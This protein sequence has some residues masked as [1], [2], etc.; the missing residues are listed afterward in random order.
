MR[1]TLNQRIPCESF[2]LVTTRSVI[3]RIATLIAGIAVEDLP[4]YLGDYEVAKD[5]INTLKQHSQTVHTA[6]HNGRKVYDQ[7]QDFH[8]RAKRTVT[9]VKRNVTR[10][11]KN[12][13]N[14][15]SGAK[16]RSSARFQKSYQRT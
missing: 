5:V 15:K 1:G 3:K 4:T 2:L 8:I 11:K 9:K 7:A 14:L 16:S 13:A 6:Y 10:Y 12:Y